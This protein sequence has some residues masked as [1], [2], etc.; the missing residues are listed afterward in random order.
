MFG[1]YGFGMGKLLLAS[2]L[3][4]VCVFQGY[5]ATQATPFGDTRAHTIGEEGKE[6]GEAEELAGLVQRMRLRRWRW[7]DGDL[8]TRGAGC[9]D[10]VCDPLYPEQVWITP[11]CESSL[12][13]LFA[14]L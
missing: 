6:R 10:N 13:F 14:I 4:A 12:R 3:L 11:V 8:S 1:S 5:L 2:L 7:S 9:L